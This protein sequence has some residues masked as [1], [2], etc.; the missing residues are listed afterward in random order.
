[1]FVTPVFLQSDKIRL[2]IVG[3]SGVQMDENVT[4]I[5]FSC[6]LK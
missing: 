4:H 3:C 1:M 2:F 5:S 6:S